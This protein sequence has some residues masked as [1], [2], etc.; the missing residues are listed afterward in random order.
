MIRHSWI[1]LLRTKRRVWRGRADAR[2]LTCALAEALARIVSALVGVVH[3]YCIAQH[4]FDAEVSSE[5]L[6]IL[7]VL[8]DD[9]NFKNVAAY[10][11]APVRVLHHVCD[12]SY[13]CVQVVVNLLLRREPVFERLLAMAEAEDAD[14]VRETCFVRDSG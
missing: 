7:D 13:V 4:R 8:S 6:R 14:H 5:A 3:D 10:H 12:C 2:T 9:S 1:T 11:A